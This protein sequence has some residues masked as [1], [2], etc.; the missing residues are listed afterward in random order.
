[1]RLLLV[2][3]A[4]A[5]LLPLSAWAAPDPFPRKAA[6][7]LDEYLQLF[8]ESATSLG[9][10]RFDDRLTD[11]SA[12][13]RERM[14][15]FY[16]RWLAETEE[17]AKLPLGPENAVDL[18]I[19][20]TNLKAGLFALDELK[21]W[22]RNPLEYNP[23]DALYPLMAR[24]FAPLDARLES[25][26]GRL[27]AIPRWLD[28][29]RANLSDPPRI[30]TETA[31]QQNAGTLALIGPELDAILASAPPLAVARLEPARARAR[32]ALVEYGRWLEKDLLPRS[33]G[34]FRL[35]WELWREKLAYTL[36]SDLTP[37][38][39]L[40]RARVELDRTQEEMASVA[41]PLF[42]RQF[43][44]REVPADRR[45]LI[46]A[47]LDRLAQ[48]RP[49][50]RTILEKA[51]RSLERTTAFVRERNLVTVPDQPV[52][53]IEMPEFARGV[54][55]A[56]CD[57]PGPLEKAGT[58]FYAISPAP[59]DWPPERVASLYREYND[60]M[61]EDLT[62][63]EAM[64]GH[65]LQ[66]WHANRFQAPTKLRAVFASGTFVE[67]WATYA[68]SV[69]AAQGYGGP[70]VRM[71]QLKMRLRLI[72]NA[73]LDQGVHAG[74]MSREEA[75]ALMQDEGFQEEGEAAGKW[76]RACLTST[77]LST[78]FVGNTEVT[79]LARTLL[80]RPDA[81][82]RAVHDAMLSF[83]SPAPRYVRRLLT[84]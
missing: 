13:G 15:A 39:I 31:I 52:E 14:R 51:R 24:D 50:N 22:Q 33:N 47:V 66:L 10:H 45:E 7:F 77:Q 83:G 46:R 74:T 56:Y 73:I 81:T 29:A 75:M 34:D 38:Q 55:V 71:Q 43:P 6:L 16:R 53:L 11:W 25:L 8:P 79:D 58:T 70:E 5:T 42:Q 26:R 78:Y 21:D 60:S 18:E 2:M 59:A 67:G 30:H 19:W 27:E 41:R 1:M 36:E 84:R 44:G 82:P 40:E 65:Y 69:M 37:A 23:G 64:P 35:G 20:R 62:I 80:A 4:L 48:D 49:D 28:V 12:A 61:L 76:R 63:H 17:L 3:V 9:D 68:E 72:L 54:A 57:S 32:E